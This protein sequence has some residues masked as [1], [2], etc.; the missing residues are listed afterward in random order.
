MAEY[1]RKEVDLSLSLLL[2]MMDAL[3][4]YG[5]DIIVVG[6]WAPYFLLKSF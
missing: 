3:K 1:Q 6:G 5:S 2:E 4:G